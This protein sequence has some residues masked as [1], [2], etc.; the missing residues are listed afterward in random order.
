MST[1]FARKGSGVRGAT[2][3]RG[4]G[5]PTFAVRC[6]WLSFL[7]NSDLRGGSFRL[8]AKAIKGLCE[9]VWTQG[10][11]SIRIGREDVCIV[12]ERDAG[13]IRIR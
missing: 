12:Y 3:K 9:G 1:P 11:G 4:F 2:G 5:P 7:A 13:E 8:T 10:T 6:P